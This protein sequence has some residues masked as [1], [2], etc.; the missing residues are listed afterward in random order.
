MGCIKLA[1]ETGAVLVP[2][3]FAASKKKS[4]A[5]WDRFLI[6]YPFSRV[7]AAHGA[8]I[9][10]PRGLADEGMENER[11]RV[12]RMMIDFDRNVDDYFKKS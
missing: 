3:S 5:S 4:L 1:T 2:F 7:V 6:F 9:E 10:I 12:E 11:R 8:P